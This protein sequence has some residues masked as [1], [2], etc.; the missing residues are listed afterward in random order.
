MSENVWDRLE[1]RVHHLHREGV[2]GIYVATEAVER[3]RA[4]EWAAGCADVY[5][6]ATSIYEERSA[7]VKRA[8]DMLTDALAALNEQAPDT[9]AG[10]RSDR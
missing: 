1:T 6:A 8:K 10:G 5:L 3:G 9:M 4:L 7:E 2:T